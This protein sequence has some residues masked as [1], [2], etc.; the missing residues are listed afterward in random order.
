MRLQTSQRKK[1]NIQPR[2]V[3]E[4]VLFPSF[5][6]LVLCAI[7]LFRAFIGS[8]TITI[9]ALKTQTAQPNV[10]GDSGQG[11]ALDVGHAPLLAGLQQKSGPLGVLTQLA[12]IADDD[13]EARQ[14]LYYPQ[15]W[16]Q[17]RLRGEHPPP[18]ARVGS[19][20]ISHKYKLLY[21]KCTKTA[22]EQA[23]VHGTD[24]E[25]CI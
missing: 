14:T 3:T 22:G 15:A 10:G 21:V 4:R 11:A 23:D 5:M 19:V 24:P 20:L 16:V 18:V 25:V 1:C 6:A 13:P 2:S 7:W 17:Q 12:Q 9:T 8:S